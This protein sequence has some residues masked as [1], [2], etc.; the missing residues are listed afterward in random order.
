MQKKFDNVSF[1]LKKSLLQ[2]GLKVLIWSMRKTF[3]VCTH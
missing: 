1:D 3:S 2:L